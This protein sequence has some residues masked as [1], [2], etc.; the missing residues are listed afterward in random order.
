[1]Q[2]QCTPSTMQVPKWAPVRF[3]STDITDIH[4]YT[5]TYMHTY[6]W[7]WFTDMHFIWCMDDCRLIDPEMENFM[8]LSFVVLEVE[9]STSVSQPPNVPAADPSIN[10]PLAIDPP[11]NQPI[12]IDP[13]INQPIS[14]DPT[15]PSPGMLT[16]QQI[17]CDVS[18]WTTLCHK[19]S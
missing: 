19:V 18:G 2:C 4:T 14:I 11:I 12:S 8:D 3:C 9:V 1:M 5:Y 10:Q 17:E 7:R 15:N 6:D 16:L 13:P